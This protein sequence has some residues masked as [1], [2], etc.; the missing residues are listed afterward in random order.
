MN[1]KKY[2]LL[3]VD[4][5]TTH[6]SSGTGEIIEIAIIRENEKGVVETF[7]S[8][9]KPVHIHTASPRALE[10]NHY[11]AHE[12]KNAPTW[13]EI[14][15]V[16]AKWLNYGV[17]V[18]HNVSFDW[19]F[20]DHHCRIARTEKRISF[21]K[22]DTQT[23][24]WEH[25]PTRGVSMDKMRKFFGWSFDRAHTALKDAEDCRRLYHTLNRA[26]WFN[27]LKWKC[28]YYFQ[29]FRRDDG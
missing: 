7:Y 12:W 24:C 15:P 2:P 8:K 9:V 26:T 6:L 18:G 3:F 4:I 13:K 27:R 19:N 20:I 1:P 23:L 14:A 29:S 5:E 25:L 10:I 11:N 28:K 21:S 17:I 22:I 16:V